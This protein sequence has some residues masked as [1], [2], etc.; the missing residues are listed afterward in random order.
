MREQQAK[1]LAEIQAK[2]DAKQT[3]EDEKKRKY[4]KKLAKARE[5]C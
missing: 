1:M 2:K 4:E 5:Q 3:E